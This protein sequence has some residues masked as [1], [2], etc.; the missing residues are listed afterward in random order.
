M[1]GSLR[2]IL[3]SFSRLFQWWVVVAP[4]EQA[5]RI[6]GGKRSTLILPGVHFR[7]PFWDRIYRQSVRLRSMGV[8]SQTVATKDGYVVELRMVINYQIDDMEEVYKTLESP[9]HVLSALAASAAAKHITRCNLDECHAA[10]IELAASEALNLEDFGLSSG[11][12]MPVRVVDLAYIKRTYRLI[13]GGLSP[14]GYWAGMDLERH[15][16]QQEY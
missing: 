14:E 10:E 15:I 8:P 6:R 4:W 1:M 9:S 12:C 7:I 16:D 13:S 2:E 11:N 5:L 3:A